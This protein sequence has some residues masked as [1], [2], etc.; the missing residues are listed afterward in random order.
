MPCFS[1]NVVCQ[2]LD[3]IPGSSAEVQVRR[4]GISPTEVAGVDQLQAFT[5][6]KYFKDLNIVSI[7]SIHE[8]TNI[9]YQ[10]FYIKSSWKVTL[11][12]FTN[13]IDK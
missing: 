7:F 10:P 11:Q 3:I 9:D 5:W 12:N 13:L 1:L 2:L 6:E 8:L 4:C